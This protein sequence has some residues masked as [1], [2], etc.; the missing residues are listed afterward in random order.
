MRAVLG[1]MCFTFAFIMVFEPVWRATP[2]D[3]M[4]VVE[5]TFWLVIVCRV[6]RGGH[7]GR[8]DVPLR[9]AQRRDRARR[10]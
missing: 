4:H 10:R 3:L 2:V 1:A 6:R 7:R 8:H 9:P 5:V